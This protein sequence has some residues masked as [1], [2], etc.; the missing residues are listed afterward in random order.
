MSELYE[1]RGIGADFEGCEIRVA[2][3]ISGDQ[4]LYE[5]EAGPRCHRCKEDA[6]EHKNCGC[7]KGKAHQGLHWLTAH[8]AKG[9]DATKETRYQAKR[10]TFTRLFGGGPPTAAD[11]VGC[12]VA[13]MEELFEALNQV[14][15]A[16]TAWDK[17]LRQCFDDG[18][19]VWRDYST[20]TNYALPVEGSKRLVY[21]AYSGRNIY[22][23]KGPHAAG[24][25]A[26]QGTAR[27]LLR[28]GTLKWRKT[29]WGRLPVLPVHDQ[30]ETIVP[31]F[32]A[33]EATQALVRCMESDVLSSPGFP[34]HI[35]VDYES[36]WTSWP[37]SS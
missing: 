14:A 36:P 26:I 35:G 37:D 5:A 17:W 15:P 33:Q 2:A 24:N 31:A 23:T 3:A 18:C 12:D 16:Y 30:L 25:G 22:V 8:T 7:G 13:V 20:G 28:D 27:E 10:G 32:E 29:R 4:Q 1:M 6:D 11:Q 9:P 19:M 21:R 34:V